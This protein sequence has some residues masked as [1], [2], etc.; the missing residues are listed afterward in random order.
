MELNNL[1]SI[2]E[3]GD[4]S[5]H[6]LFANLED[7]IHYDGVKDV[8]PQELNQNLKKVHL[9]D[10]RQ[11]EEFVGDLGHI[12][13]AELIVLDTLSENLE[14]IPK[15]KAVVFVCRSGGRSA[16]AAAYAIENGFKNVFNL[17]GGMLLWNELHFGTEA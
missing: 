10:V 16:R 5:E 6:T 3:N 15:D 1:N 9:I 11:P 13:N 14:K 7:N 2:T 8:S 17:K 12:P 4:R